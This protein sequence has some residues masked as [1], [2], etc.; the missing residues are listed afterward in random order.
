MCITLNTKLKYIMLLVYENKCVL[1]QYFLRFQ[2]AEE[3]LYFTDISSLHGLY[4]VQL[5]IEY[6]T[7]HY[8]TATRLCHPQ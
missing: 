8:P 6:C 3:R 1:F 5:P 4:D 2:K 7:N